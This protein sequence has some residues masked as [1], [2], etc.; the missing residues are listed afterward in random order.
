MI[1]LDAKEF[2]KSQNNSNKYFDVVIQ[3]VAESNGELLLREYNETLINYNL[4]MSRHSFVA[5][6][7]HESFEKIIP[8]LF[9]SEEN[10]KSFAQF[11]K[12]SFNEAMK[13]K[14]LQSKRFLTLIKKVLTNFNT[15][16]V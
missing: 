4:Q 1:P 10:K 5:L 2:S 7:E 9:K 12:I 13:N 14:D 6:L 15:L 16:A 8:M 3:S 11:L